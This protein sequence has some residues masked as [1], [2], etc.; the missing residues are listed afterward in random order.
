MRRKAKIDVQFQIRRRLGHEVPP[1]F[2]ERANI[3]LWSQAFRQHYGSERVQPNLKFRHHSKVA[4]AT[5]QS[6]EQFRIL[7]SAG[8]DEG[9]VGRDES[10]S[11]YVVARQSESTCEPSRSSAQDQSGGARV[12]D[13]SSGKNQSCLLRSGIDRS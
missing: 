12:R 4:A 13:H 7:F 9:A 8:T 11:F 1:G 5:S 6:P 3:G 10:E 2:K